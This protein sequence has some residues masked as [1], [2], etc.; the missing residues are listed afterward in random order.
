MPP[1]DTVMVFTWPS[2]LPSPAPIRHRSCGIHFLN[3]LYICFH[4]SHSSS[5]LFIRHISSFLI[6]CSLLS[7]VNSS[8]FH[9]QLLFPIDAADGC[10]LLF[11]IPASCS[12]PPRS[13]RTVRALQNQFI[14]S[15]GL[16]G[17]LPLHNRIHGFFLH[18]GKRI[19][20]SLVD[21]LL[22]HTVSHRHLDC[23][24]V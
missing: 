3:G 12:K 11:V 14:I 23:R 6:L 2:F 16:D 19:H 9:D 17:Y 22:S 15:S 24:I 8:H 21:H 13:C 10:R 4:K 20:L 5:P 1:Q 7:A 18:H